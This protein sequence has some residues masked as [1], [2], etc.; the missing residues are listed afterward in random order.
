MFIKDKSSM[1]Y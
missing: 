1:E